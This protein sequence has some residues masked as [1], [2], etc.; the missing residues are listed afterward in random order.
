MTRTFRAGGLVA[1]LM[2]ASCS[3]GSPARPDVTPTGPSV[4]EL[5][6]VERHAR[7]FDEHTPR[8]PAGSQQ[9]QVAATYILGHLQLAGYAVRLDSVP[10]ANTVN[11]TNVIAV[12]PGGRA[13]EVILAVAYD[14]E[15][16]G[17]GSS[18]LTLGVFLEMARALRVAEPA[19][20][21][22]FVALGAEHAAVSG[23]HLGSRRMAELLRDEDSDVFVIVLDGVS[24]R[25]DLAVEGERAA[26]LEEPGAQRDSSLDPASLA[27]ADVF[28]RAGYDTVVA[29]GGQETVARALLE[30]LVDEVG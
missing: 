28:R 26:E 15:P 20:S 7:Q 13:P 1:C 5:D 27:T 2:L 21:V 11:S 22:E 12:P 4:V 17:G 10:V 9:E 8:R 24:M 30:F 14:S 19:H 18:G 23:G 29:G 6:V 3:P 25:G 16:G